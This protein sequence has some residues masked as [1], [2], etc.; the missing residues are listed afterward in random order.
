MAW[1]ES[2]TV[3]ARH[4]KCLELAFDLN[5]KVVQVLGHLHALWHTVLEQQED[6]DLSRWSDAMIAQ[7][8]LWEGNPSEFVTRLREREWLD[9][10]LV[11]D[12]IE[13]VGPFLTKKY[14]SGDVERLRAIWSVHGLKYGKGNRKFCK[15][16]ASRKR[17][18]GERKVT[19]PFPSLPIP[20]SP[21]LTKPIR[22]VCKSEKRQALEDFELTPELAAWAMHEFRV[23][24]PDDVFREFKTYWRD[25]PEKKLRSDWDATFRNRIRELAAR[26]T[27]RPQ[28]T[29]PLPPPQMKCA[30]VNSGKCE[31]YAKHPSRYCETH[32]LLVKKAQARV[33]GATLG[34]VEDVQPIKLLSQIGQSM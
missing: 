10:H 22:I 25:Q 5:V 29:G 23:V 9:G 16:K 2:H 3:L 8:A 27:L 28:P 14:S 17:V 32:G 6:G 33:T 7:A 1:V 34:E 20:S 15:Q 21:D 4:R 31:E 12:W 18:D 11:H 13:Y 26:G 24:I 19:I 30:W